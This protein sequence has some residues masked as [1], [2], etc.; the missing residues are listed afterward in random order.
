MNTLST[1]IISKSGNYL[2]GAFGIVTA[3]SWNEAVKKTIDKYIHR[4]ETIPAYYLYAT[5]MTIFTIFVTIGIN[6]LYKELEL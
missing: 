6:E 4:T 1:Q 5:T 3:L 2:I